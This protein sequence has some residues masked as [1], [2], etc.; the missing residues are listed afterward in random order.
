VKAAFLAE[1]R[2]RTLVVAAAARVGMTVSTLYNRRRR[3]SAFDAAWTAAAEASFRWTWQRLGG[4]R[5]RRQWDGKPTARRLRFAG[6]RR[7]ACLEALG[8]KG[9]R[10]RAARSA[11]VDRRTVRRGL[12]S[13]PDFALAGDSAL[14]LGRARQAR[15]A[16]AGRA[17]AA[18]ALQA[19]RRAGFRRASRAGEQFRP[20]ASGFGRLAAGPAG[21]P[22]AAA[23]A[24]AGHHPAEAKARAD[25]DGRVQA[26]AKAVAARAGFLLSEA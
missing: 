14:E 24:R 25:R 17:R 6:A 8:R 19:D 22:P 18:G 26:R 3:D 13:D 11:R 15:R 1:L 7:A 21:E 2:R 16:A 9:D 12:R 10:I 5:W 4:G 20:A 23:G